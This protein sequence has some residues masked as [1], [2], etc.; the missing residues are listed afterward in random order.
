MPTY[1]Y[2]A[3]R[4]KYHLVRNKTTGLWICAT[5]ENIRACAVTMQ[6]STYLLSFL[7]IVA[8]I[9]MFLIDRRGR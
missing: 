9:P 8:I 3:R 1:N 6:F 4:F 2:I 5:R 7:V